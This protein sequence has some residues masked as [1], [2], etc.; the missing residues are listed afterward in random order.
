MSRCNDAVTKT[1][2]L[3]EIIDNA[4]AL[5]IECQDWLLSIA[6][7]MAFTRYCL[8]NQGCFFRLQVK[9]NSKNQPHN[10]SQKQGKYA[11]N[12]R[13]PPLN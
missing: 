2:T 1:K 12:I 11:V 4:S 3:N 7:G 8:L 13:P 10:Y 9:P 5:P 6:K